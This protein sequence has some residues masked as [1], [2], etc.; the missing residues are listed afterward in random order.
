MAF[1]DPALYSIISTVIELLL[2][3]QTQGEESKTPPLNVSKNF[4]I[5]F[6]YAL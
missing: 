2:T 6:K 3:A 1:S 4:Y 5:F